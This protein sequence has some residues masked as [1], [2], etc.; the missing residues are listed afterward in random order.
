METYFYP[1]KK[2]KDWLCDPKTHVYMYVSEAHVFLQQE[3]MQLK[4][5]FTSFYTLGAPHHFVC[6]FIKWDL[7]EEFNKPPTKMFLQY[8]MKLSA[9]RWG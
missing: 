1:E 9:R 5:K 4:N 2:T 3:K 7:F 8:L 6:L